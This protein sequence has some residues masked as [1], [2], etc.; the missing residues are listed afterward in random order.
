MNVGKYSYEILNYKAL[1][2]RVELLDSP[3]IAP[4][5]KRSVRVRFYNR[6][7]NAKR[8]RLTPYLPEGWSAVLPERSVMLEMMI[9]QNENGTEITFE[10]EAGE[11][12]EGVNFAYLQATGELFVQPVMIPIVFVG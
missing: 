9:N 10:I 11:R 6:F 5:E 1:W 3:R 4:H 2:A 12:V 7:N 8:L